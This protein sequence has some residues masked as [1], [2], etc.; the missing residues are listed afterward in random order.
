MMS[1]LTPKVKPVPGGTVW[2]WTRLTI[3]ALAVCAVGA[4][5]APAWGGS[6]D[7]TLRRDGSKA[8]PFVAD[9]SKDTADRSGGPTLR[10]DGSKAVPFVA[11]VSGQSDA[12]T[13]IASDGFDWGDAA[14][15]AG[16]GAAAVLLALAAASAVRGR[17]LIRTPS[18]HSGAASG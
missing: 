3:T 1:I 14:I 8:V 15:G 6:D 13:A 7:I 16:L 9:V 17:R 12:E 11:D 18:P 4:L 5:A 2:V 10:R